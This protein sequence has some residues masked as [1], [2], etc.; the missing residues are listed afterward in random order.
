MFVTAKRTYEL[1]RRAERQ[2]ETRQ[3][4]VEA[5]IALHTTAGPSRTTISAI[6]EQAG[7]QRHTVYS[8]FPDERTLGLA[9]SGLYAERYPL[10]DPEPWRAIAGPERRLRRGLTAWY[11]YYARHAEEL[12]PIVRDIDTDPLTREL[13]TLRFGPRLDHARDVLAE[14]FHARGARR[15]RLLAALDTFLDLHTWRALSRAA[16]GD[17]EAVDVAVRAI[18]AQ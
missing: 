5:A 2:E 12:L 7:V 17:A 9:C 14:P 11:D 13:M 10:P 18:C 8:H 15:T 6:A 16:G 1:K 3:R 4:I